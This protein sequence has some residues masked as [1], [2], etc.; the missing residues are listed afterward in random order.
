[1]TRA[2]LYLLLNRPWPRVLRRIL[3]EAWLDRAGASVTEF[4]IIAPVLVL[5]G[6]GVFEFGRLILLTQKMQAGSFVLADLATRDGMLS[7]NQV[8]SMFMALGDLLQ[9]F[10]LGDRSTAFISGVEAEKEGKAVLL[11]QRGGGGK[12]LVKS[13]VGTKTGGKVKLPESLVLAQGQTLVVTEVFY[14]FRPLFGLF[15]FGKKRPPLRRVAY[16]QPRA[17]S[18]AEILP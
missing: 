4:A 3:R 1:M 17:G 5:L 14:D 7:E 6:L 10:D 8:Q 11:W 12:L 16:Y 18:L 9:P 13:G 15:D 2:S